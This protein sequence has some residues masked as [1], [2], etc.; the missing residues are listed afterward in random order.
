MNLEIIKNIPFAEKKFLVS[1][2]CLMFR[3]L[4]E[5][6]KVILDKSLT[7][8]L[9][10]SVKLNSLEN[11]KSISI[12]ETIFSLLEPEQSQLIK[13]DFI[14]KNDK[15][16]YLEYFSTTAYYKLKHKSINM[17]LFLLYA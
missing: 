12:F 2:A 3:K 4:Q 8:K 16:W 5:S 9:S 7:M 6:S 10:D 11:I 15:F 17:F 14:N 13:N 1:E